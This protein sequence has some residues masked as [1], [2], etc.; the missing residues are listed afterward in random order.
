MNL[1]QSFV[2][3][4]SGAGGAQSISAAEA[5]QRI[6][7]SRPP[8]VVDVRT[9][10]E[11]RSGHIIGA[12]LL[13]LNELDSRMGELPKDREILCVCQSGARS[14]S[15]ARQLAAA[16]Y[17][18]LNLSGGMSAWSMAGLPVKRGG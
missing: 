7:S 6:E 3:A 10:S 8:L 15:A 9:A 1:I 5:N 2:K 4:L 17:T 16:G 11:F 14:S 18:V 12:K 13:P